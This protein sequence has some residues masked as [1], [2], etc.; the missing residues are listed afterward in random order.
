MLEF[1][2]VKRAPRVRIV[3]GVPIRNDGGRFE[4]SAELLGHNFSREYKKRI[5]E[6]LR[7]VMRKETKP[8]Y[9]AK[10]GAGGALHFF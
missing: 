10:S 9:F 4:Q 5:T 7:S 2:A 8:F 3:V 6:L 1:V